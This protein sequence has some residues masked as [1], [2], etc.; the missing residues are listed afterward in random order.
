MG[1]PP[2]N[3]FQRLVL[4]GFAFKAVVIGGGYATGRELAEFFVPLGPRGGLLGIAVATLLWSVVCAATFAF[5]QATG[6]LDYRSFFR[7]L[8]GR[9]GVLF[10]LGYLALL[11][12]VLSVFGAAA[13]EIGRD[14][15]TWPPVAGALLLAAL[16]TAVTAF[17]D[18]AVERV[19]KYVSIFLY[20]V[21][22]LFLTMALV[23]FGSRIGAHWNT[24][25]EP[26]QA[27][28][29]G[30]AYAGYNVVG[31]AVILPVTRHMRSRR[32]AVVSGL[33]C[34]PLAM[35]PAALFFVCMSAFYP[36]IGQAT[37]PS[38]FLLTRLGVPAFRM[39]FE[40][41][42]FAALLESGVGCVHALNQ[43]VAV[44]LAHRGRAMG[45][46]LRVALASGVLAAAIL[47]AD[48]FG[49]VALIAHGYRALTLL[50]LAIYIAPLLSLGLWRLWPRRRAV[51]A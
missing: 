47:M 42:I 16:I 28:G 48:R 17:G 3:L 40:T 11:I 8:L 25:V 2:P 45:R 37:L 19:F 35:A 43:R 7:H 34:G 6:S 51:A 4:P 36:Q 10:E 20:L 9:F 12:L 39:V 41:M 30:I 46:G 21:Y 44:T 31:A 26:L 14:L 27:A 15:L 13:G 38:D 22:G 29:Q 18:E 5:A 24:P 50:F 49:L 33:L 23:A 32:D 1:Q